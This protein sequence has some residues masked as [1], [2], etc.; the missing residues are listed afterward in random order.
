M[1]NFLKNIKIQTG[2]ATPIFATP[3]KWSRFIFGKKGFKLTNVVNLKVSM[4]MV[5]KFHKIR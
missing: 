2:H 4:R 5:V 3:R 1:Q